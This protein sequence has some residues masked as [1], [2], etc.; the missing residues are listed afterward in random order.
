[1]NATLSI[2]I[3]TSPV[4]VVNPPLLLNPGTY[5]LSTFAHMD[6][7]SGNGPYNY[8]WAWEFRSTASGTVNGNPQCARDDTGT[9]FFFLFPK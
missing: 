1:M 3:T 9:L 8:T 5:W 7:T 2:P 6:S 4:F